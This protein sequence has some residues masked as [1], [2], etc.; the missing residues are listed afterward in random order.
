MLAE[1]EGSETD[2]VPGTTAVAHCWCIEIRGCE[3]I[4]AVWQARTGSLTS[5]TYWV[6][7][8]ASGLDMVRGR[9]FVLGR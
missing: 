5:Q 7:N 1:V 9:R 8:Q 4:R 2:M 6:L 3:G